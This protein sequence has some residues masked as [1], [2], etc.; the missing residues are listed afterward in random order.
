MDR[1]DVIST[2]NTLI[3]TS[4][5]G[6]E[7]FRTC[8]DNVKNPTLRAFFI[9]KAECC[10]QG[11][12]QLQEIVREMGGDPETG[13]SLS[14]AAHRFWSISAARFPAWTTT[15]SSTNASA[16]RTAPKRPTR[17]R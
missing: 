2:L 17:R 14:G 9:Q 10:R 13:G 11:A 12:V 3:V 4:K 7:G 16:A 8:V 15:P 6:E 5:D 1:D